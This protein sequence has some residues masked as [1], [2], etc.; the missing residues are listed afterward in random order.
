MPSNLASLDL[1]LLGPWLAIALGAIVVFLIAFKI[2]GRMIRTSIRIAILVGG[3]AIV[4]AALCALTTFL[5][6]G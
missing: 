4:A 1:G 6:R 5:N 3:L 2:V